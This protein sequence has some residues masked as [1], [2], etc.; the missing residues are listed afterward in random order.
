M[1]LTDICE[2]KV[3]ISAIDIRTLLQLYKLYSKYCRIY[4]ININLISPKPSDDN[5]V[6]IKVIIVVLNLKSKN[7]II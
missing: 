6:S 7:K 4:S 1:F 5:T 2:R 3:G